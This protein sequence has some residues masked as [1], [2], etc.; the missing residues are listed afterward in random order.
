MNQ[1]SP[2]ILQL[3]MVPLMDIIIERNAQRN[4]H[5][6]VIHAL[7]NVDR[8]SARIEFNFTLVDLSRRVKI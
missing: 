8:L 7:V 4:F 5:V 6:N 3:F 1:G 2:I